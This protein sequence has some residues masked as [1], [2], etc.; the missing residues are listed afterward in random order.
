MKPYTPAIR[1]AA[2]LALALAAPRST[3][4]AADSITEA[5][6]TGSV[7]LNARLRYEY[8]AQD[9]LDDAHAP[10]IRTR[11]GYST[12]AFS[13]LK[14]RFEAENITAIDSDGY[15]QAGLNPGGAGKV[16][17][18][19]PE[20]TEVN[21]V[22]LNYAGEYLSA[23]L[24]RQRYV[25]DNARFVGDV[26]WR[27]NNQTFD[28]LTVTATPVD[29]LKI[30]YGYLWQI[31]RVLGRE[32]PAGRWKSSSH[33]LNA[34][35]V[36]TPT[37]SATGFVYLLDFSNAAANASATYGITA[38]GSQ[39]I[40]A[41]AGR[42]LTW[43]AGY[44]LQTDYADQPTDYTAS[45]YVAELGYAQAQYNLGLGYE[46]LGS[47]DGRK[48]FA[49]PLATLHAFNGWADQFLGT[50]AA[51]LKD[52]YA[53]VGTTLPGAIKAKLVYHDF[54]SDSGSTG[55]GSEWDILLARKFDA[56][57]TALLKAAD[58]NG[59]DSY[60]DVTKFW[61]QVEFSF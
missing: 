16:V 42:K 24:G 5:L 33:L 61:A 58:F 4:L 14:A 23:T 30:N 38:Q 29:A 57:W 45:Y 48:G 34:H 60:V 1:R 31:N 2:L 20:T 47:D 21:Q 56:H 18:A 28:A 10:T 26:G 11:L 40:G 49:T 36:I 46:V 54:R 55:Y 39:P 53:W 27:Q 3:G 59:R 6:T 22:W 15:N 7:S 37:I 12:A 8:A 19:D 25:L 17:V 32:H 51:G 35:Y 44:A 41:E 52:A 43:R 9:G 50:P 13:G